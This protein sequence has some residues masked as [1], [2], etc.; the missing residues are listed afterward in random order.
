MTI[1][2]LVFWYACV[3]GVLLLA[4]IAALLWHRFDKKNFSLKINWSGVLARIRVNLPGREFWLKTVFAAFTALAAGLAV[5][6]F[7][8]PYGSGFALAALSVIG[9][10]LV[11]CL[12]KWLA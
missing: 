11:F 2:E 7:L 12:P 10:A 3:F 5:V 4:L 6:V 9:L 1:G 8:L